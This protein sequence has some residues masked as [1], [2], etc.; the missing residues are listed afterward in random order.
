MSMLLSGLPWACTYWCKS[1][2]QSSPENCWSLSFPFWHWYSIPLPKHKSPKYFFP[3]SR[4]LPS[5]PWHRRM[6]RI[7]LSPSHWAL[8][9]VSSISYQFLLVILFSLSPLS[10][11]SKKWKVRC[12]WAYG[13][14]H[15]REGPIFRELRFGLSS[16]LTRAEAIGASMYLLI[17]RFLISFSWW[18]VKY[19]D[20]DLSWTVWL[21]ISHY[22]GTHSQCRIQAR[23]HGAKICAQVLSF[24][25][26][27]SRIRSIETKRAYTYSC[28]PSSLGEG[29]CTS[30]WHLGVRSASEVCIW[31]FR[32]TQPPLE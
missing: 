31:V 22:W 15:W 1:G 25:N 13:C 16:G 30:Q 24:M 6:F 2:R 11:F 3:H 4:L 23:C 19:S 32:W 17:L 29:L 12:W 7:T 27:R 26:H 10:R 9:I 28:W 5:F 21:A 14:W 8:L 20:W 18:P